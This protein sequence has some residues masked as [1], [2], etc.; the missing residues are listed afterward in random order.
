MDTTSLLSHLDHAVADY[1]AHYRAL[2]RGYDH[3]ERILGAMRNFLAKRRIADIDCKNFG[4]WRQTFSHLHPNTRHLYEG[5]VYKFCRFRRRSEPTCFLPDPASLVRPVPYALP[6]PIEPAQIA[7]MLALASALAPTRQSPLRPAVMRIA[8]VLLYTSGLRLGELLRLKLDDVDLQAGVLRIRESKFHKSRWVPLSPSAKTELR[9]YLTA[10]Q[11]RGMNM[12]AS[13]PLLCNRQ[14]GWRPYS[15]GGMQHALRAL[16]NA[17]KI[18]NPQGRCPRVHDVRHAFAVEALRRWYAEHA[19]VQVNLPKLALY[20][21]HVSI[22]ST[23]YYL[24]WM[25]VVLAHASERFE[26]H[27][28]SLVDGGA[29]EH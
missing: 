25:P 15:A 19:D 14:H 2:G 1:L 17:A 4:Q 7:K 29:D 12:R 28:G 27:C 18:R 16:F 5:A 24:R 23:A 21:G 10:R 6:T 13:A 22:A 9:T 26:H 11:A 3:E 20:M 8:L